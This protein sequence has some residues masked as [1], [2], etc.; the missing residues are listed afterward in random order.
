MDTLKEKQAFLVEMTKKTVSALVSGAGAGAP[1]PK[2]VAESAYEFAEATYD[3]LKAKGWIGRA[4]TSQP[5]EQPAA[6]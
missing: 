2:M 4:T 1:D 3:V 5:S 6:N